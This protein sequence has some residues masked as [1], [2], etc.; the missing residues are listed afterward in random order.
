M[1][2]YVAKERKTIYAAQFNPENGEI[3]E[4]VY[5]VRPWQGT[6]LGTVRTIQ[7]QEITVHPGEWIV[8]EPQDPNRHYPVDKDYFAEHYEKG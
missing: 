2:K 6:T 7:G 1:E 8:R 3:P 5:N 4:G